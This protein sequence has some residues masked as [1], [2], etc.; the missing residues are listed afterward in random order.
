MLATSESGYALRMNFLCHAIPYLDQP[1]LAISTGLPDWMSV[2]DRKVRVR[3]KMAALHLDSDDGPLGQIAGG[4]V[5]HI[6]DDRWF[7]G[8]EAFVQTNLELA[9]QLR[10]RLPGD[11]GFRPMF[12]G[13][14]LIEMLLDSYWIRDD[15]QLAETYY[16]AIARADSNVIQQAVVTMTGK[17]V[18]GLVPVIE[19][20]CQVQFL[21]DYL[22]HGKL[23]MRINQVM[24][25]VGLSQLPGTLVDWLGEADQL[26]ESRRVRMLCPPGGDDPFGLAG[27]S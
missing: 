15:R 21:Y 13:H 17:S 18:T 2:V 14:I 11:T 1:L 23:L 16:D 25:R 9:V 3:G 10:D 4:V 8:T 22:D 24:T 19:R 27:G 6:E 26:V 7:H 20:F 5:R 12:V